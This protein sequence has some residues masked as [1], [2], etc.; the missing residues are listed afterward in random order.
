MDALRRSLY[1]ASEAHGHV[2]QE[3]V[4]Q[5][6]LQLSTLAAAVDAEDAAEGPIHDFLSVP[7]SEQTLRA[8]RH[9]RVDAVGD[10]A[11]SN[12]STPSTRG[13]IW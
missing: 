2:P 11:S 8:K 9:R 13:V 12:T 1:D 5:H 4:A 3:I 7:I 10:I 6:E